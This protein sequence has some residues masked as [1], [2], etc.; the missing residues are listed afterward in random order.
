MDFYLNSDYKKNNEKN[1]QIIKSININLNQREKKKYFKEKEN[2]FKIY[3]NMLSRINHNKNNKNMKKCYSQ[4]NINDEILSEKIDEKNNENNN[5]E[6]ILISNRLQKTQINIDNY[7]FQNPLNSFNII[8]QNKKIYQDI[9]KNYKGSMISEYEKSINNVN[10]IIKLKDNKQS[11]KVKIFPYIYKSLGNNNEEN[12]TFNKKYNLLYNFENNKSNILTSLNNGLSK[13]LNK[14]NKIYILKNIIQ[15][16]AWGFPESRIEFSFAQEED[17]YIIYGGYNSSRISNL[18]KFNPNELS[19]SMIKED[20]IKNEN[21]YGHTSALR[22]GYLYIFGGVYLLRNIF[23]SL[24][25]FDLKKNKW[26]F[27]K[28]NSLKEKFLFRRNHIGCS[29]GNQMFIYGGIDEDNRYLNDYYIL[30]YHPLKWSV[31]IINRTVDIPCL[32][33]HSCCLVIQKEVRDHPKFSIYEIPLCH[34]KNDN[35]KEKG[36]Y[37]F[38]GLLSKNNALNSNLYVLRVG[39]KPLDWIIL[40][41]KGIPPSKRYGSSMSFY[42][43]GNL[44]IIHGGRNNMQTIN[45]ALNDTFLLDLYT[46]NWIKVEYYDKIKKVSPRFFHQSFVH[47]NNFFVFGG[48]N[49][50]NYLG[51]EMLILEMDSNKRCLKELQEINHL[52]IM[53]SS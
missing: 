39:K 5:R 1:I 33:Y 41:T 38:G 40:K 24:E 18:W 23:A 8:C 7:R 48:T 3:K 51:S 20:G 32:A 34:I 22:N 26:S 35:I 52:K 30:N 13:L 12:I 4:G 31:P 47:E 28:I 46:L 27:P 42:E 9:L 49:G 19:W 45:Y 37:I 11:P 16:P 15:Y 10:P 2:T 50:F 29:I 6:K 53:N 21:R 43:L 44:L 14:R 36:L 25:I 17:N